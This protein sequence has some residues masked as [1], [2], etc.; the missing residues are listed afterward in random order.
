[1]SV[2]QVMGRSGGSTLGQRNPFWGFNTPEEVKQMVRCLKKTEHGNFRKVL[3]SECCT[4][5]I[6]LFHEVLITDTHECGN[7][8]SFEGISQTCNNMFYSIMPMVLVTVSLCFL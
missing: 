4:C 3:K 6:Q 8:F 5:S 7:H 1:M 2:V